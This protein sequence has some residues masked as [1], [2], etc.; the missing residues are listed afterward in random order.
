MTKI[1]KLT[2]TVLIGALCFTDC[3]ADDRET[4]AKRVIKRDRP[5]TVVQQVNRYLPY[6]VFSSTK[7]TEGVVRLSYQ[8]DERNR[9]WVLEIRSNDPRL[10]EYV[11]TKLNGQLVADPGNDHARIKYLK[12]VFKLY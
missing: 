9:L 12:L 7:D 10:E 3:L 5:L 1:L 2:A 11:L 4:L 6:P 8:V